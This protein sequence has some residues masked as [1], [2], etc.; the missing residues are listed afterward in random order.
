MDNT[1]VDSMKK[2]G[3]DYISGNIANHINMYH[4]IA[5]FL[6]PPLKSLRMFSSS[7]KAEIINETKN[8]LDS[9][10]PSPQQQSIPHEPRSSIHSS[11]A[12]QM[13]QNDNEYEQESEDEIEL[14]LHMQ[15]NMTDIELLKWWF[16]H[17]NRFPRLY[18]LACSVY[19][20][21]ASSAAVERVFSSAGHTV[22]SRPNLNPSS[23][24]DLLFLKSN[25]DLK[26]N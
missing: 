12:L 8:L 18:K 16:T 23:L 24:D 13:W 2:A 25:S 22:K 26:F 15:Y 21:P 5:T 3:R 17:R 10:F 14:Y 11:K 19:S 1:I 20:T 4:K 9:M 7:E 6:C